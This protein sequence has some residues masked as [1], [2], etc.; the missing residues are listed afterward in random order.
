MLR[1]RGRYWLVAVAGV[2]SACGLPTRQDVQQAEF[3]ESMGQAVQELQASQQDLYE[4]VD[5]LA[6]LVG[7]QDSLLRN[8]ANLLGAPLPPR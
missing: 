1:T 3:V 4:R 7:R 8:L 2:L 6:M 5:S